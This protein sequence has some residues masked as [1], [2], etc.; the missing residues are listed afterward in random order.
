MQQFLNKKCKITIN[1]AGK[2]LYFTALNV[3]SINDTHICFIDKFD[4]Q[5]S[6]RI[7]DIVE[8]EEINEAN[9]NGS[10]R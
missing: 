7:V 8:I 9:G 3:T 4:T 6:F 1:L 2:L 10:R 5:R